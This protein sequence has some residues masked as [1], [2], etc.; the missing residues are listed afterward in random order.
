MPAFESAQL[1]ESA[2]FTVR[3]TFQLQF[4]AL[5]NGKDSIL[6]YLA[7]ALGGREK[8]A[9]VF[10]SHVMVC[11]LRQLDVWPDGAVLTEQLYVHTKVMVVDDERAIIGSANIN[12]RSMM[13]DRDSEI[14]VLVEEEAFAGGLRSDL[15]KEHFGLS[16]VGL[17][18]HDPAKHAAFSMRSDRTDVRDAILRAFTHPESRE[19][20]QVWQDAAAENA[21][22][23][24]CMARR[25]RRLYICMSYILYACPKP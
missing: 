18:S 15:W 17:P 25:R 3:L 11:G 21:G 10:Y 9:H 19:C 8:G 5:V 24:A 2:A 7:A 23:Y 12:D 16:C 1:F 6:G 14:A 4:N 13:G 22:I 20:F